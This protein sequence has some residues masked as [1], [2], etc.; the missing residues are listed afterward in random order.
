MIAEI[1]VVDEISP[2]LLNFIEHTPRYERAL[3][4]SVGWWY[5]R[6]IKSEI[7]SGHAGNVEYPERWPLQ[8]R[9]KLDPKAPIQWYG[10]MAKAIGYEYSNGVVKIGWTS[11]TSAR[12]GDLQ[13]KGFSKTVTERMRNY[14]KS[15]GINLSGKTER[16]NIPARPIYDPIAIEMSPRVA[17]YVEEKIQGYIR[18]NIE[19]GKKNRRKYKVY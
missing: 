9:R 12:Y 6:E 5:Q 2:M 1:N 17:P 13:E 11:P 7:H 10:R 15:V 18:G 3:G 8:E 4:K 14:F 16:L 19:F